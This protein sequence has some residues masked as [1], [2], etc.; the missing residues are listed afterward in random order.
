MIV[1]AEETQTGAKREVKSD[2]AGR[3]QFPLLPPGNYKVSAQASGFEDVQI[4]D[5]RLLVNSPLTLNI[6]FN[7]V[8]T[9]AGSVTVSAEGT[10]VN[11][12]DATIGN[13][14]GTRP[15]L[16]LPLE[17]RN[18]VGLL[19]LQP[20]VTFIGDDSGHRNGSVNG[21]KNDQANVTLD[22]VDVN[23]QQNR[24]AFTSVLRVTLDSVQEFRVTTTNANADAG[25]SSGAQV[26]LVTK[27]GTNEIHGSLYEFHRNTVTTANS[28]VNNAAGVPRPKLIRNVFGGSAGGP[29]Q[30]NRL[31]YFFNFEGRRDARELAVERTVPTETFRQGILQ[32]IR[33]NNT[34]GTVTPDE[35]KRIDPLGIGVNQAVLELFRAYPL[36]NATTGLPL[37]VSNGRFWP[38]NWQWQG[39]ATA[40]SDVP[41]L[42]T[43]RNAPAPP[44]GRSGANLFSDPLA[45]R[46]AFD[47]TMPGGIGNRNVIRGDGFFTIDVGLGKRF[48]L[49]WSEGHTLQI[50]AE[51]FNVT[52]AVRFDLP[53]LSL[54]SLS[55]FG[56]FSDVLT[57]PRVMQFGARYDF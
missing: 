48:V 29:I 47:F 33:T 44:G 24:S 4:N 30:K 2:E 35:L 17:G 12:V 32:Y 40:I 34:V 31:F 50:R 9:V 28:F 43:N 8:G 41:A 25:R 20:G 11:T 54:G 1:V 38:T 15:I 55:T 23:D 14:F 57:Q 51:A 7:R 42:G 6:T 46:N 3:F 53:S 49:P 13:A 56:R 39:F 36:P 5:V 21:G 37:S 26:S 52:N 19:S 27:R 16:E 10:L 22:G 45:A 18:V